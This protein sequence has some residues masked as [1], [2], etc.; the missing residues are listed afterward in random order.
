VPQLD[1]ATRIAVPDASAGAVV[2]GRRVA[3]SHAFRGHDETAVDQRAGHRPLAV[4]NAAGTFGRS[5]A[6]PVA[7]TIRG[8][9]LT[10]G[11]ELAARIGDLFRAMRRS[12]DGERDDGNREPAA[13]RPDRTASLSVCASAAREGRAERSGCRSSPSVPHVLPTTVAVT[14]GW[15]LS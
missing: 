4:G 11:D 3:A 2:T 9:Q 8:D 14:Y 5:C 1:S 7:G 6:T 13:S 10:L 12:R 15:W